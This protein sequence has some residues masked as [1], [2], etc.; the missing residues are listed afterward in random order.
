MASTAGASPEVRFGPPYWPSR[1]L[2]PEKLRIVN[3]IDGS[4]CRLPDLHE[5]EVILVN[6]RSRHHVAELLAS[7]PEHLAVTIVDNSHNCDG[8]RELA[9][10]RKS[11]RYVDGG[12]QGYAR[13]ANRGAH[14]ATA[15]F[16]VFV[17]PD[18]RPTA[19]QLSAL[20]GGLRLD[21]SA[22]AHAGIPMGP[23]GRP[24]IGAG[25]WEPSVRRSLVYSAGLQRLFPQA[26]LFA[27]PNIGEPLSVDWAGGT[28]MAVRREQ[29][30]ALYGFDEAFYVYS[31]DVSFGRRG[32]QQGLR[33][34]LRTDIIVPHSAGSS[35]A[36]P[37]EMLRLRG[38]SF[39]QYVERY[40]CPVEAAV[41]RGILTVGALFRGTLQ[42]FRGD[43]AAA[44][45][46]LA[47]ATGAIT[48]RAYVGGVEVARSRAIESADPA[49]LG[50]GRLG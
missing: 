41:M 28:C 46:N 13:A 14:S 31:E 1:W 43:P 21:P 20:V 30:L 8:V 27:R 29:F 19:D 45:L 33:S 18:S 26:G 11:V 24:Q 10:A 44:Q 36:P 9:A 50:A 38:A 32:R 2:Y 35:G 42:F 25:G 17:N 3:Q 12:G 47:Y 39:A 23:G 40:H 48:G 6:Y 4:Q 34:V 16:L 49:A 15:R 7:W 37:R 5:V 22:V